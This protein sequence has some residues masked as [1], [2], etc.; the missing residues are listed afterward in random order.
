VPNPVEL[1][2]PSHKRVLCAL[3]ILLSCSWAFEMYSVGM[4]GAVAMANFGTIHFR[5]IVHLGELCRW[6]FLFN[7]VSSEEPWLES[8]YMY[9][10]VVVSAIIALYMPMAAGIGC[11][12]GMRVSF[13]LC[14]PVGD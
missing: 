10:W 2:A 1:W 8:K 13:D 3:I 9:I 14:T 11:G 5:S 12:S 7:K 4:R 6:L